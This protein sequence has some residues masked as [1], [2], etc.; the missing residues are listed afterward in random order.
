L[1]DTHV[2]SGVEGAQHHQLHQLPLGENPTQ[3]EKEPEEIDLS[4]RCWKDEDGE[5][6][7]RETPDVPCETSG[8]G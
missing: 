1:L 6:Q 3:E 4:D 5:P 2:P 8:D 7:A